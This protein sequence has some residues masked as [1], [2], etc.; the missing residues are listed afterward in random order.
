ML[1]IAARI[2]FVIQ[3]RRFVP[4][5]ESRSVPVVSLI[6]PGKRIPSP[7][8]RMAQAIAPRSELTRSIDPLCGYEIGMKLLTDERG[9][10]G[11]DRR[12]GFIIGFAQCVSIPLENKGTSRNR[13]H[14][15]GL[16]NGN[17]PATSVGFR[18]DK[19]SR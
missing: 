11:T 1:P 2:L 5:R 12:I 3:S 14:E 16:R 15:R 17:L 6:A 7:V 10:F 4:R 9:I 13:R 8:V 18:R 19:G